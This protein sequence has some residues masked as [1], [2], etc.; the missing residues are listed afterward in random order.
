VGVSNKSQAARIATTRL[1]EE[2]GGYGP[3]EQLAARKLVFNTTVLALRVMVGDIISL[4]H[5]WLPNSGYAEGRVT[6]WTLNPDYSISLEAT[7]TTD[8]MYDL[9]FG[10]KPDDV[11]ADPPRPDV[12]PSIAGLA[13]MPND[14][15]PAANDPVYTDPAER[16][17]GLWQDYTITRDGTWTPAIWV[18]GEFPIN[19]F[20]STDQ[21]RIVGAIPSSGGTLNG[22][23]TIY[24][25]VTREN[26]NHESA[27]PSNVTA[28]WLAPGL[29]NQK[30][31]LAL[32]P[33]L[34]GFGTSYKLWAGTDR[35][36]I[37]EQFSFASTVTTIDVPGPLHPM[38][39]MFP[40]GAATKIAIA[41]KHV[42]H[43]GVAGVLVTGVPAAN[44]LQSDDFK[45]STDDWVGC[46]LSAIADF[47]D[48]SAPLWN[49]K[50]TL[51]DAPSGTFTVT[52]NATGVEAGDVLIMR[53]V[54]RTVSTDLRTVTDPMWNNSVGRN[55]FPG[56]AG[57]APGAEV[58]RVL[59]VLRGTGAGQYRFIVANDETSITVGLPFDIAPD[60]TSLM[61]VEAADWV[62]TNETSAMSATTGG[63]LIQI[64]MRVDNLRDSVALVGGFL[65]DDQGR[66]TS[67]AV[68]VYREIYIFGQPPTVRIIGPDPLDPD[69]K[70][71]QAFEADHTIRVDTSLNEITLNLPPLYVYQGRT[72]MIWN[73]GGNSVIVNAFSGEL[74]W[75]GTTTTTLDQQG[76]SLKVTAA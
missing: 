42:W 50:V 20:V 60:A 10:V 18:E 45:N 70:P 49:F 34:Q 25:A 35:R 69:G 7:P 17:F 75:D 28:L 26:A 9:T 64:R 24:A 33:P 66:R 5:D 51:F 40:Q 19:T 39:Q 27:V 48:G 61:I 56:S 41:A 68:A 23:Q 59:R 55:Q 71:W 31:S 15:I 54:A 67:E 30:I 65:I 44:Q 36:L 72:L 8:H 4:S 76:A 37:A 73:D 2:V 38:T 53:S 6:K 11:H 12:L 16:S 29:V 3:A 57:L 52:P 22:G 1:R 14:E 74:L 58:D 47:S 32:V 13:W 62:Y 43:S 21:P 63:H 46:I